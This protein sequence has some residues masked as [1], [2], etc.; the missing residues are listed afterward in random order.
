M[1]GLLGWH[2]LTAMKQPAFPLIE[3]HHRIISRKIN[4]SQKILQ[5]RIICFKNLIAPFLRQGNAMSNISVPEVDQPLYGSN[6]LLHCL[7]VAQIIGETDLDLIP[8]GFLL[9]FNLPV[10]CREFWYG[11]SVVFLFEKKN[12]FADEVVPVPEL[13]LIELFPEQPVDSPALAVGTQVFFGRDKAQVFQDIEEHILHELYLQERVL[14]V[15]HLPE[16][17][18]NEIGVFF[19]HILPG[20][21]ELSI[22]HAFDGL[23]D[24]FP[25]GQRLYSYVL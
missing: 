2:Y 3:L 6:I 25:V 14:L 20:L 8:F 13:G 18:R 22:S 1:Y 17:E 19:D 5:Q 12:G 10:C 16:R 11:K 24:L 15:H 21:I 23:K 9:Q 7:Y 4:G